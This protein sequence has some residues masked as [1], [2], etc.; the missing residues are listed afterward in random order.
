MRILLVLA[1]GL[2]LSAAGPVAAQDRDAARRL[3]LAAQYLELTQGPSMKKTIEGYFEQTFA[4]SEVPADQRDWLSENM[5]A[6]FEVAMA[7]TFADLT[8]D[9][10]E[11]YTLEELEVMVAFSE[12]PLGRSV[13]DKSFEMGIRT[14]AVMMPHLTAAFAQLGEKF[15]ARFDCAA[16]EGAQTG[17]PAD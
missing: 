3:V 17:K 15:C 8:D 1:F 5:T 7:E 6:A 16:S 12:T 2:S 10:A 13:S 4:K 9:V 11:I 14:Q